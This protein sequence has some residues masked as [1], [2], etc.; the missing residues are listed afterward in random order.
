MRIAD[1]YGL[2][3]QI[4][5]YNFRLGGLK[6]MSSYN[7]ALPPKDAVTRSKL[8]SAKSGSGVAANARNNCGAMLAR[9]CRHRRCDKNG[10]SSC[11]SLA[12]FWYAF[13]MLRNG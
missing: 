10:T 7:T 3:E 4:S 9:K 2:V 5:T 8:F 11:A 12:R 1:R 6:L 13:G